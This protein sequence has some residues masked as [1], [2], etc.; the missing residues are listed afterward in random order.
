M[1]VR[2]LQAQTPTPSFLL[3]LKYFKELSTKCMKHQIEFDLNKLI[4]Q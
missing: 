3:L 1:A 2:P 4:L